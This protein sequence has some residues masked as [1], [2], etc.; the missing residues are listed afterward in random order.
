MKTKKTKTTN[1][2]IKRTMREIKMREE[3][4]IQKEKVEYDYQEFNIRLRMMTENN[5]LRS[6]FL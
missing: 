1:T 3:T 4:L 2:F 6:L 5:Q